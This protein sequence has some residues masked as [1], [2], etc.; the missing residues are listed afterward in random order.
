[1]LAHLHPAPGGP[2]DELVRGRRRARDAVL[3]ADHRA[4]HVVR[5]EA[6]DVGRV[7]V[8]DR[9]AERALQLGSLAQP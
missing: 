6:V 1:M 4:E 5:A 8:L 2:A 7:D 3:A 9:N